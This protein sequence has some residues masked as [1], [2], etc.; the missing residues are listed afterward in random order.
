M[1]REY[2]IDLEI[3]IGYISFTVTSKN[4]AGEE[5][6]E[7]FGIRMFDSGETND[8][9]R[10]KNQDRRMFRNVRRV[11]RR[12]VH[13]KERVKNYL[14]KI[15]LVN[16]SS[17]KVWQEKNGNQNIFLT[18]LKG[19]DEKLS[20]EEIAACIIHICNHRGY[21]EFYDTYSY[22]DEGTI[23]AGLAEFERV[24]KAGNYRS[25]AD[26]ILNDD[27]FKTTTDFPNY[28]NH[29]NGDR[30]ILIKRSYQRKELL[31]ILYTQQKFYPVLT[32]QNINFLC[33]KIVFAQRDFETGPGDENDK[34]RKF[35]GFLDSVGKCIYYKEENRAFRSTVIADIYT[36]VTWF[37]QVTYLDN[38]GKS[39]GLSSEIAKKIIDAALMNP[40]ITE[41]DI[42]VIIKGFGLQM[43][44]GVSQK[45]KFT[46]CLKTL[47]VLKDALQF[48][49]YDYEALVGENQFSLDGTSKLNTLCNLLTE[50]ITIKRREKLLKKNGWNE[51]LCKYLSKKS[52]AGT[53]NV[54]ERYMLDAINAFLQGEA[55]SD[56]KARRLQELH[57][58]SEMKTK[59]KYLPAL[60]KVVSEDFASNI[61]LIKAL[62]EMRKVVN[63]IIRMYGSPTYINVGIHEN[64]GRSY[65][66][67]QK[68]MKLNTSSDKV[69]KRLKEL[70]KR[71][72]IYGRFIARYFASYLKD[73]LLF[74]NEDVQNVRIAKGRIS[75]KL[76]DVFEKLSEYR[77]LSKDF[78]SPN[79]SYKQNKKFKGELIDH[80]PLPKEKYKNTSIIKVD[81]L[82]H[83]TVLSANKYY[84]VEIYLDRDGRTALRGIRYVDLVKRNK[85]L[86]LVTDYPEGYKEHL[87]YLF[88]NDYIKIFDGKGNLKFEG[89]YRNVKAITRNLLHVRNSNET[90][91]VYI[92]VTQKDVFKKYS[93][94][95]L[96]KI[97]GEVK[98]SVPYK[99][100]PD[101]V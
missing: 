42:K 51:A 12:K 94:D 13:R 20:P 48:S 18:R 5:K 38:D 21:S 99:M 55:Y 63:A 14:Q 45:N 58:N 36:L 43:L 74:S 78:T 64:F 67:R 22:K 49:G 46:D 66:V 41:K 62:N 4:Y 75:S 39:V 3:G 30:N 61:V 87:I 40:N 25:V 100:L 6:L 27:I 85:K 24:F 91:D 76:E 33:D 52:F 23:E 93:I 60:E 7:D 92:Y 65:K 96:G 79:V 70:K 59:Q 44:K 53:V 19:L 32:N 73:N 72:F 34:T 8:Y 82:G 2:N 17:L 47:V 11:L 26:M 88:Q 1:D 83:E 57:I 16:G 98:S 29:K 89:Y 69:N 28:H 10:L 95:V 50:N 15:E 84:C 80:N 31:D 54:C 90:T 9:K 77:A 35:L 71:D 97:E 68:L 56:F 86:Y 101:L 81:K 37:S